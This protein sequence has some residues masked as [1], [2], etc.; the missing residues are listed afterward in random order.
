MTGSNIIINPQKTIDHDT[1]NTTTINNQVYV[2]RKSCCNVNCIFNLIV[3]TIL[4]TILSFSIFAFVMFAKVNNYTSNDETCGTFGNLTEMKMTKSLWDI[5]NWKYFSNNTNGGYFIQRCPTFTHDA[6]IYNA[7]KLVG[8]TDGKIFDLL[9]KYYIRDC[10]GNENYYVEAGDLVKRVIN[11]NLVFTS[12]VAYFPNGTVHSYIDTAILITGTVKL[13]N[14]SG[15]VIAEMNKDVVDL[16][17]QWTYR[18]HDSIYVNMDTLV[19]ITSKLSFIPSFADK[20]FNSGKDSSNDKTDVCNGLMGWGIAC[21]ILLGF[22]IIS[23]ILIL[24]HL[25]CP[26]MK[27]CFDKMNA[28]CMKCVGCR[29]CC[30]DDKKVS[31]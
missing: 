4:V 6:D 27:P 23:I 26:C 20:L 22:I 1:N 14:P 31:V 8:R 16:V 24:L 3:I 21:W 17:W 10:H 28:C 5:Y 12:L 25:F 15:I 13:R 19:A 7:G 2:P 29:W 11:S 18:I 30:C 9:A